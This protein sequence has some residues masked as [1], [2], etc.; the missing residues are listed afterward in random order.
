MGLFDALKSVLGS[1][2]SG[3]IAK[4]AASD[5]VDGVGSALYRKADAVREDFEEA[6]RARRE[7]RERE[8]AA[9]RERAQRAADAR[10]I[11]DELA[12]LKARV[13]S[14]GD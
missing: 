1:K 2:G 11:D 5:A 6:A 8:E 4:R 10:A 12:A 9:R 13:E 14:D 3:E 7:K